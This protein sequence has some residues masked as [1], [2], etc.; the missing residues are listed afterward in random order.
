MWGLQ[1]AMAW[2]DILG[3]TVSIIALS[4]IKAECEMNTGMVA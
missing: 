3:L 1:R 4:E 2:L